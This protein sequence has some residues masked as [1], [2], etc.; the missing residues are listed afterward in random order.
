MINFE[1]FVC[2][3]TVRAPVFIRHPQTNTEKLVYYLD[4]WFVIT[5]Y[6]VAGLWPSKYLNNWSQLVLHWT[7]INIGGLKVD[8]IVL[9]VSA[10]YWCPNMYYIIGQ[11]PMHI[12]S[13]YCP[14]VFLC[15]TSQNQK[16]TSVPT[17]TYCVNIFLRSA[18]AKSVRFTV[19]LIS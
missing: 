12:C 15:R 2:A 5:P 7:V 6:Y 18:I 14:T 4:E 8:C 11:H 19:K 9:H 16:C 13:T 17:F 10:E 1:T 3:G